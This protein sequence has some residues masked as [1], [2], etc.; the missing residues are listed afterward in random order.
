MVFPLNAF[1]LVDL[2]GKMTV[3][4]PILKSGVRTCDSLSR[5]PRPEGL[6]GPRREHT[7]SFDGTVRVTKGRKGRGSDLRSPRHRLD[8]P[9]PSPPSRVNE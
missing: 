2:T 4:S 3:P 7:V 6:P 5:L 1:P 9:C 8:A